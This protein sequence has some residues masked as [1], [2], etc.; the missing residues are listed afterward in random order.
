V[1]SAAGLPVAP[2][3]Q[4]TSSD[5]AVA[6]ARSIG[7][8]VVLKAAGFER[9]HRGEEGGVAV[10]LHDDGDVVAAYARMS[11]S[12]GKAMDLAAVQRM[13]GPGADVLVGA[14]QHPSFG[15]AISVGI[16]G[17]MAAANPQLPTRILPLTDVDAEVLV[18]QSP[19]AP[20]LGAE[21][22]DGAATRSFEQ[23]VLRLSALLDQVP[24]I[25]DLLLNPVIVSGGDAWI[26]DAWMRIAPYKWDDGPAVRRLT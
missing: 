16:G 7:F 23:F 22:S 19:I 15:G 4:V 10:D 12:L 9:Y 5:E 13:V 21:A 2:Q 20:L 18:A 26:V 17:L 3:R 24:E 8:P 1:L 14:H 11:A 25:A 6:A